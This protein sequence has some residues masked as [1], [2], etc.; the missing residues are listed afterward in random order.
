MSDIK[1]TSIIN[2]WVSTEG[3]NGM[4]T[5]YVYYSVLVVRKDGTR[6]IQ[7]GKANEINWLLPYLRTPMDELDEIRSTVK[8]LRQD[9]NEI[10]TE[11]MN[12]VVDSLYPIPDIQDMNEIQAQNLLRQY[13]LIPVPMVA[14]PEGT[15]AIG[16]VRSFR[17]CSENFKQVEVEIF[18]TL[19]EMKGRPES[20]ALAELEQAGFKVETVHQVVTGYPNGV[21]IGVFRSDEHKMNVTLNVSSSVPETKGMLLADAVREL[22]ALGYKVTTAGH[23]D[24]QPKDTVIQ[25]NNVTS[26]EIMLQF[27]LGA[28]NIETE[29]IV[30]QAETM[31]GSSGDSY[32][33]KASYN[34]DINNLILYMICHTGVKNKHTVIGIGMKSI[35]GDHPSVV[36]YG[37]LEAGTSVEMKITMHVE[38][39]PDELEFVLKTQY[40]TLVKKE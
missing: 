17:R 36:T 24:S 5:N 37:P 34:R 12:Y 28:K 35:S 15:P 9:M 13:G 10:V 19:P 25:W 33:A 1:Y 2:A 30:V 6:Q 21:V 31:A 23:Y 14:Y 7:E 22:E 32:T 29:N 39:V 26:G 3:S 40:G 27:S 11:K 38:D 16:T 4:M 20:E 8:G 18:H